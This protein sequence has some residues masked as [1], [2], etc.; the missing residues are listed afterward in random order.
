M[1]VTGNLVN[2]T[3]RKIEIAQVVKKMLYIKKAKKNFVFLD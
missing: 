3:S 1:N 2:N